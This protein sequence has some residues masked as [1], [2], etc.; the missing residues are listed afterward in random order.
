ME[1][2]ADSLGGGGEST[3]LIVFEKGLENFQKG[4]CSIW[5]QLV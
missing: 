4:H 5:P 2:K 3:Q 1:S